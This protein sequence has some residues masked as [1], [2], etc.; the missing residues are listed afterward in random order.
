MVRATVWVRV[1]PRGRVRSRAAERVLDLAAE[2]GRYLPISPNTCLHLAISPHLSPPLPTSPYL[3]LPLPASPYI[4][5]HL[6]GTE[7]VLNVAAEA[8]RG[9]GGV[10]DEL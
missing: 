1:R 7:R 5:L 8:G 10:R 3:S 9:T 2:A 4:S 6:P